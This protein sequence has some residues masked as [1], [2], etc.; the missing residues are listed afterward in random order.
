[1]KLSIL[2]N[3][4]LLISPDLAKGDEGLCDKAGLVAAE[5]HG[6]PSQ[7]MLAI[8][9]VETGRLTDGK[10]QPW[11]WAVN[12][13]GDSY[14][15]ENGD[16]AVAFTADSI[17]RG[18]KSLD[19]GCFQ[20]NLRWHGSSF[21]SFEQMFDPQLNANYAAKFLVKQHAL[22]GNWVDAVARFHSSTPGLAEIYIS[23]VERVL[24]DLSYGAQ[25]P[26]QR[27]EIVEILPPKKNPIPLFRNGMNG[28]LASLMPL[29]ASGQPF[30][31][32]KQE[33]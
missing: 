15:F 33:W 14:W 13:D 23:K 27:E 1:M 19:I 3:T 11:P 22:T 30:V 7:I 9:R 20:L 17:S 4:L 29:F 25:M 18:L 26:K 12:Q 5:K 21:A 6:I 32:M 24:T 8:T 28:G 2:L 31:V 10:L 16:E